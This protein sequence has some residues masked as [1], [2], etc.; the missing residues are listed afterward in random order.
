M[1]SGGKGAWGAGGA[2]ACALEWII[3]LIFALFR[4]SGLN[5][6]VGGELQC[7]LLHARV[8]F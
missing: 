5:D 8:L 7:A 6:Q 4:F 2:N 3:F 1:G